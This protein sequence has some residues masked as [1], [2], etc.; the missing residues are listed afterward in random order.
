MEGRECKASLA[1]CWR[2][3]IGASNG[4]DRTVEGTTGVI[5]A[6]ISGDATTAPLHKD[7]VERSE[8]ERPWPSLAFKSV[9]LG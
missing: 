8:E 9:E 3:I 4:E 5:A 7:V 6:T 2:F 1:T